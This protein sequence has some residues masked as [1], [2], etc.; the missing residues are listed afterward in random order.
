MV[1]MAEERPNRRAG[2]RI[3]SSPGERRR[4]RLIDD[5]LA[6]PGA[7]AAEADR[8]RRRTARRRIVGASLAAGIVIGGAVGFT[9]W[10]GDQEETTPPDIDPTTDAGASVLVVVERDDGRAASVALVSAQSGGSSRVMLFPPALVTV[11]PG[12]GERPLGDSHRLG[13]V[14]L[15]ELTVTNLL[16]VRIDARVAHDASSLAGVL[17]RE[18]T[19]ELL[20]P[21]VVTDGDSESVLVAEGTQSVDAA[22]AARLLIEVGSDDQ[23]TWLVRQGAVWEAIAAAVAND[24]ATL[25]RLLERVQ[26]DPGLASQALGN[27]AQSEDLLVT[28]VPV[29]R[30]SVGDDESYAFDA[31]SPGD[32]VAGAFPFLALA[33]EPRVKVEILSGNDVIGSTR[34][35]A[36]LMIRQGYR[37]LLTDNAGTQVDETEIIAQSRDVQEAAVAVQRLLGTGSVFLNADQ[38]SGVVDLTIIVGSDLAGG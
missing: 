34:P 24:A 38:P 22:L 13:G 9:L 17:D 15:V 1:S 27:A 37:V 10:V 30:I 5:G 3:R 8:R 14:E 4:S 19:V 35:I 23:L 2:R 25:D 12:F 33:E 29:Q 32:V 28:A 11:V 6:A 16:G 18:V 36:A 20:D 21:F 31:D 26:G 7:A